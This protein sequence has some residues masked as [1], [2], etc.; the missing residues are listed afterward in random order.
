MLFLL[1]PQSLVHFF[2]P[3]PLMFL[4]KLET[5]SLFWEHF[6]RYFRCFLRSS[7]YFGRRFR[8][9][10][11]FY[12]LKTMVSLVSMETSYKNLA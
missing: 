6:R 9:F 1:I 10:P 11:R 4:V 5:I 3:F 2:F 7:C 12:E 8:N